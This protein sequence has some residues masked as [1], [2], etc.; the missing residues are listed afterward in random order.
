MLF[1]SKSGGASWVI[2]F[3]GNPGKQYD[4]SRHNVGFHTS[5]ALEREQHIKINRLRFN[6]LTATGALGG[7]KVLFLKPQTYMNLSGNAVGP[8]AAFYKIPPERVIVVCDDI[9]LPV[10][11]LRIRTKGSAGGHNGLKSII[12]VLG[13]DEF[14]RIKIGVGSPPPS[15][16]ENEIINWVLGG[17]TKSDGE[18]IDSACK[19]ALD[20][21]SMYISEGADRA[22]NKFN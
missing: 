16:T 4:G 21:L 6:A 9:S 8:A 17:F 22:M 19:R 7:E 3:L 15:A 10:G 2:V 20:A 11:R 14:P 5:E 13:T 1:G 12:S 18:L